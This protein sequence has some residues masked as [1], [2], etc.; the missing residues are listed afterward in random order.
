MP[1]Q[2]AFL[3]FLFLIYRFRYSDGLRCPF[4]VRDPRASDY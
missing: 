1:E 4:Y 2:F 3:S